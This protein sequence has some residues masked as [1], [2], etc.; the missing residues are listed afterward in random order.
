MEASFKSFGLE[1]FIREF[2][3]LK[4]WSEYYKKREDEFEKEMFA[5]VLG[6]EP[7]NYYSA[8]ENMRMQNRLGM[9][10]HTGSDGSL[11]ATARV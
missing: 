2:L 8:W 7:D 10:I 9:H 11:G 5:E 3:G 4:D 1:E 6:F